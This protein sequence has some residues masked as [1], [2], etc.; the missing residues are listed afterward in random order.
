M[1]KSIIL[2]SPYCEVR[3]RISNLTLDLIRFYLE[4]NGYS[5]KQYDLSG[6]DPEY[7]K[8][9]DLLGEL[10]Q[11]IIGITGY[12]RERFHAYRLIRKVKQEYPTATV[13]VGGHHF[14]YLPEQTLEK[15]PDVDIVVRGEGE[16][17]FKEICD[18]ITNDKDLSEIDGITFRGQEKD[19]ATGKKQIISTKDAAIE[20]EI[21]KFRTWDASDFENDHKWELTSPKMDPG[22]K[23]ISIMATRGCPSACN[24]CSLS[25]DIVR[26]RSIENVV[27]EIEGKVNISGIKKV[28]FKDSSLT[29]NKNYVRELC[30]EILA[31]KLDIQW[32]CY[33]RVDMSSDLLDYMRKAGCTAVEVALESGSPKV[34]K[35]IGKGISIDKY[36]NFCQ[37]AYELGIKV[38]TFIIVSSTDET[39]EDALMTYDVLYETADYTYDFGVQV[40]RITPDTK[41][42][43]IAREK[44]VIPVDFDWFDESYRN[45]DETLFKT[46]MYGT[47]PLYIEK[48]SI[49]EIQAILEKYETLR[50]QSF[51]YSDALWNVITNNLSPNM[52]KKLTLKGLYRK[53]NRLIVMLFNVRKTKGKVAYYSK[54][55]V[56]IEAI[57]RPQWQEI[58]KRNFRI[59]FD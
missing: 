55:K 45:K 33:S 27:D 13:V 34:L 18:A 59:K 24:F 50:N 3:Y 21:D 52:L 25:T 4:D 42:D 35:S 40:T 23:Y 49:H 31:R 6:S 16:I 11:P 30:D 22:N 54:P 37:H 12:T 10:Q 1:K 32:Q 14:G 20:R 46:D 2:L 56:D 51:V 28:S 9:A 44:K 38:W 5:V 15:L 36:K 17:T 7:N 39:Y 57:N 19:I 47:L 8:L 48:M 29:V 26:F 41:L 53:I 58:K 43:S